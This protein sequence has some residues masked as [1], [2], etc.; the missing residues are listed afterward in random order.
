MTPEQQMAA[1]HECLQSAFQAD[2]AAMRALMCNRVPCNQ[3]LADHP[4]IVCRPAG[5]ADYVQVGALG[6]LNGVLAA[7]GLPPMKIVFSDDPQPCFLGF[8]PSELPETP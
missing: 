7:L 5:A 1:V 6:L 3:A 4:L 8:R 2:P